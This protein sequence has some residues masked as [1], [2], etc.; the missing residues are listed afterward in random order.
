VEHPGFQASLHEKVR[1]E[2]GASVRLDTK[3]ELGA[4]QQAIRVTADVTPLG[5]DDAKIQNIMSDVMIEGLPTVMSDNMRSPFDLAAITA[6]VNGGDQDF[7]IGGGQA[8][9]FGVMLDGASAN[10][11]RAGSTLWAAVN[12]PALGAI[13]EF[14][15]ETNGFKAEF[16]RAGGGLVT[17]VSNAVFG[18]PLDAPPTSR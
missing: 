18:I 17:F 1:L 16:G 13:T 3:L 6:Q 14:A 9:S 4:V 7:R 12:A 10:T 5:S 2:A 8:A 15:V 11:N